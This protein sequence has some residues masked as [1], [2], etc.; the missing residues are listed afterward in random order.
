[1]RFE[2]KVYEDSLG[3]RKG[4][5]ETGENMFLAEDFIKEIDRQ[6]QLL[7]VS[8]RTED[9]RALFEPA[10]ILVRSYGFSMLNNYLKDSPFGKVID[11]ED[12]G[13]DKI[14]YKGIRIINISDSREETTINL[15]K[16]NHIEVVFRAKEKKEDEQKG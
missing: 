15:R 6:M 4:K 10:A 14:Y 9:R 11:L 13:R 5:L 16:L 1:M 7:R 12:T 2:D 3:H 8:L